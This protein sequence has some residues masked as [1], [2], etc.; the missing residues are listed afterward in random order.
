MANFTDILE[1]QLIHDINQRCSWKKLFHKYQWLTKYIYYSFH[2]QVSYDRGKRAISRLFIRLVKHWIVR[3]R[4]YLT[5][6]KN[7]LIAIFQS[8]TDPN[9]LK[10]IPV[11]APWNKN[12]KTRIMR[13]V[14]F[15]QRH[16]IEKIRVKR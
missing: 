16:Q 9:F 5:E 3:F 10:F 1:T 13:G 15:H 8:S 14:T 2:L 4:D 12:L 11:V 6:K 7:V